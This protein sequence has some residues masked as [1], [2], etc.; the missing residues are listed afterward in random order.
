VQQLVDSKYPID[1]PNFKGKTALSFAATKKTHIEV[2]KVLLDGG[3]NPNFT[4]FDGKGPLYWALFKPN[5]KAIKILVKK[6][7]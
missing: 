5:N 4:S 1:V 6:G 3:A 7:A 2:M